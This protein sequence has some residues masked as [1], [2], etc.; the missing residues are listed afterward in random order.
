ML[1][2]QINPF[3]RYARYLKLSRSSHYDE[4][5]APD[6]RL[7]YA[8]GG[9]GKIKVG[10]ITYEMP[11]H[12]LLIFHSGIPYHIEAPADFAEYIAINFDHTRAAAHLNIP[13]KPEPP[14]KFKESM[15]TDPCRFEDSEPLSEVLYVREITVIQKTLVRLLG[16]YTQQLLYY[17]EKCGYLLAECI[18]ECLRCLQIGQVPGATESSHAVISYVQEHYAQALS[19]Q[20]VAK[21]FGYHPKYISALIK[22]MT[23]MPLHRYVLHLRLMYA[24]RMLENTG[25]SMG[26][27]ASAAG[28][29][30]VAYF[31]AYFKKHFG[32][33]P[34]KY[35]MG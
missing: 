29:C 4:V 25:M 35:R 28:F 16:E 1:F 15:R 5:I 8:V 6:A 13:I 18:A 26:E 19:N 12:A 23:G 34:S 10:H 30:D 20:S 17:S 9:Y 7:F 3:I 22:R 24:A 11:P 27:V 33:P 31:S 21:T 2:S 32:T 14:T